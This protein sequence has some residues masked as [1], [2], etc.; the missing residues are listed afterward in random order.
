MLHVAELKKYCIFLVVES[1]MKIEVPQSCIQVHFSERTQLLS[2]TGYDVRFSSVSLAMYISILLSISY[3]CHISVGTQHCTTLY[4][5]FLYAP[6]SFLFCMN[7][8]IKCLPVFFFYFNIH[9][10]YTQS[11]G[12]SILNCILCTIMYVTSTSMTLQLLLCLQKTK[13]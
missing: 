9:L 12:I 2:T 3:M 8:S 10:E 5:Y 11:I 13:N 4:I 7:Q 6:F 1:K